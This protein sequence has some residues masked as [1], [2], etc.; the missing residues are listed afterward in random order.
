[1]RKNSSPTTPAAQTAPRNSM[2]FMAP[3]VVSTT[4]KVPNNADDIEDRDRLLLVEPHVDQTVVHMPAIGF[5]R[6]LSRRIRRK[7]ANEVSKIGSP[8]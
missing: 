4:P 3:L 2:A 1:M 6:F 8:R 5:H 7:K